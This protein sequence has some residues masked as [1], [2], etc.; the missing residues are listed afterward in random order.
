ML[1]VQHQEEHA[2]LMALIVKRPVILKNI[3][4]EKFKEQVTEELRTAIQQIELR[5]EQMEFQGRRM[6]ADVKKRDQKR[7]MGLQDE[8]RNEKQR[9]LQ[10]KANLEERLQE[11]RG[12]EPGSEFISGTY[13]AP[14]KID[15]GDDIRA[16]LSQAEIIVKDGI[17]VQ[18]LE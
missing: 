4:T 3:V 7:A 14:V 1:Y 5:L 13:D 11:V 12:L 15:V 9:Q 2:S 6:I 17:V 18:I 10:L 16:K 8:F